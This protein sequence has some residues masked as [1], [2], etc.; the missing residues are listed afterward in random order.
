MNSPMLMPAGPKHLTHSRSHSRRAAVCNDLYLFNYLFCH[1]IRNTLYSLY[2]QEIQ[3]YRGLAAEHSHKH[4]YL[5]ASLVYL[6]HL[7]VE[8][9][10]RPVD[11]H[12]CI[13][14]REVDRV[15][16]R[17]LCCLHAAQELVYLFLLKRHRV[18]ARADKAGHARRVAHDV[19]RLVVYDHVY[20]HVAW[21]DLLLLFNAAAAFDLDGAL[22]RH[23]HVENFVSEAKRLDALAQV[24]RNCVL[25]ACV[26]MDRIPCSP[27]TDVSCFAIRMRLRI[28]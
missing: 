19:P 4:L 13:A 7:A 22:G 2:L 27:D 8:L 15:F 21:V 28:R 6:A 26:G 11:D 12:D 10:K 20:E 24:A 1:K 23:N 16:D 25:I 17:A 18:N 3:L 9:L 5:A 14:N